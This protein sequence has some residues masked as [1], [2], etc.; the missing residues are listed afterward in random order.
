MNKRLREVG[1][2]GCWDG[3]FLREEVWVRVRAGQGGRVGVREEEVVGGEGK[4]R[5]EV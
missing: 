3:Y 5:R 4:G 1:V 2:E